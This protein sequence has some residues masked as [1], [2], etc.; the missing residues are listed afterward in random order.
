MHINKKKTFKRVS[1][2][3]AKRVEGCTSATCPFRLNG[4]D[5][6]GTANLCDCAQDLKDLASQLTREAGRL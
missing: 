2:A 5:S 3:I 4:D 6:A 1:N